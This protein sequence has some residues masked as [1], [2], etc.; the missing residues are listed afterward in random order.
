MGLM[1]LVEK[2]LH[3]RTLSISTFPASTGA[4]VVEGELKDDRKTGVYLPSGEFRQPA[5]IHHM[6]IRL[7]IEPVGMMIKD[8][9]VEMLSHPREEC[10]ETVESVYHVK[11]LSIRSG[12]S[13]TVKEKLGGGN[14]CAHLTNL[15]IAMGSAAIQGVYAYVAGDEEAVSRNTVKEALIAGIE[16][17]CYVWRKEGPALKKLKELIRK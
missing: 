1:E 16:D 14:G 15:L 13:A 10:M 7:L 2:P 4:V 3:T 6:I 9:E 11:G 12:F 5:I 8:V 17:T